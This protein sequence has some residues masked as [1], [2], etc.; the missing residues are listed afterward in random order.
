MS[1]LSRYLVGAVL[2]VLA[3]GWTRVNS[4]VEGPTLISFTPNHGFTVADLPSAAALVVAAW[5]FLTAHRHRPAP[6]AGATRS[7]P[8]AAPADRD[9]TTRLTD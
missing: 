2:A 5:I 3:L 7:T 8:S 1:S 4:A 6:A 9:Q